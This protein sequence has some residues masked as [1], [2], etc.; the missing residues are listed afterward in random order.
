MGKKNIFS[1]NDYQKLKRANDKRL[2]YF[3]MEDRDLMKDLI[4]E[5]DIRGASRAYIEVVRTD[6]INA[7]IH[8]EHSHKSVKRD[9]KGILGGNVEE[10]IDEIMEAAPQRTDKQNLIMA[11]GDAFFTYIFVLGITA[12]ISGSRY[13]FVFGPPLLAIILL[14][15]FALF[16][17]TRNTGRNAKNEEARRHSGGQYKFIVVAVTSASAALSHMVLNLPEPW[18]INS[19]IPVLISGMCWLSLYD[20]D[21]KINDDKLTDI[22]KNYTD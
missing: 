8:E 11:I 22:Q 12:G 21:S 4:T 10:A 19:W 14:S 16:F 7:M 2:K 20:W 13:R 5:L 18:Y 15:F 9:L 1:K 17:I 3:E 6:L